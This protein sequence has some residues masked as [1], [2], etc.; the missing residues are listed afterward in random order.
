MT[1]VWE[2][3]RELAMNKKLAYVDTQR[4]TAKEL[5]LRREVY[6]DLRPSDLLEYAF[7]LI[8]QYVNILHI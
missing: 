7:I 2:G 6:A 3:R 4:P 8:S 5:S 1:E